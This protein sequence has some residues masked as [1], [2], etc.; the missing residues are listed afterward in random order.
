MV[1]VLGRRCMTMGSNGDSSRSWLCD[2]VALYLIILED[3]NCIG[4]SSLA[5][6]VFN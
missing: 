6:N 5:L 3:K 2:N 4:L 1:T